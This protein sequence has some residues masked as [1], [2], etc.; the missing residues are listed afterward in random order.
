MLIV[1]HHWLDSVVAVGVV[2]RVA[3]AYVGLRPR[4]LIPLRL[5]KLVSGLL[6]QVAISERPNSRPFGAF[7]LAPR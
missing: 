4:K 1:I 3:A 5:L 6:E 7:H 2:A